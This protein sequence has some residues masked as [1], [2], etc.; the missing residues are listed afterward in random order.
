MQLMSST[1]MRH[2]PET[3]KSTWLLNIPAG[4]KTIKPFHVASILHYCIHIIR[5][6]GPRCICMSPRYGKL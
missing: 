6:K 5:E 2:S 1:E 3:E 4:F